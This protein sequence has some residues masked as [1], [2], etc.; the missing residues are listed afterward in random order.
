MLRDTPRQAILVA[1]RNTLE[2]NPAVVYKSIFIGE[3]IDLVESISDWNCTPIDIDIGEVSL[4]SLI[5]TLSSR[6]QAILI[7]SEVHQARLAKHIASVAKKVS[8]ESRILVFGRA[9]TFIPQYFER[10]PFDVVHLSGDREATIKSFIDSFDA[11]SNEIVGAAI[12]NTDGTYRRTKPR[13]LDS[14]EWPFPALGKMEVEKYKQFTE[15]TH[16]ADYTKRL[17]ITVSKGCEWNCAYCGASREEGQVDRR[18]EIEP[19][20]DWFE[21]EDV[22]GL[23]CMIHLYA[24]DLFFDAAW[25]RRF[26]SSYRERKPGF[27]WRGVTTTRTLQDAA[28]VAA[29][30]ENGCEELAIGIEH[31]RKQSQT[32]VK[33]TLQ[34]IRTASR[35][36]RASGIL[37]KGLVML[38]YPGQKDGDVRYLEEIAEEEQ[39][40]VRYTGYTPLHK[41]RR[42]SAGQLD[43]I[44]LEEYDRRTY[45]DSSECGLSA[46]FFYD[47]I[48]TNGG[49]FIPGVSTVR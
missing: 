9:T 16:G 2:H 36:A 8:P 29:A 31:V 47:R 35:N 46:E 41:L 38:G 3:T 27:R 19:L 26:T 37:L 18:R 1:L 40:V 43:S 45:F 10:A 13:T 33:S 32:S 5:R 39:M 44:S 34:E 11:A 17:S 20:F 42:L 21:R 15:R 49:Y 14:T 23:G 48:V 22:A 25:I 30:G 4:T 6:P 7:W 28:T 12:R 24:S